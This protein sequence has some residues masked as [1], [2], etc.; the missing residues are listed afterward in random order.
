MI[1]DATVD[2]HLL[3]HFGQPTKTAKFSWGIHLVHVRH[4]AASRTDE[5]VD[6]YVTVG[7]RLARSGPHTTE[8]FIGLTP[9]QDDVAG[10]LAALW[11]YQTKQNVTFDHGHTIPGEKPLWRDTGLD[12]MLVLRQANSV[13][14][15][16]T[17]GQEH[18]EFMQVVPI[19]SDERRSV[20]REGVDAFLR[21]WEDRAVPFWDSRRR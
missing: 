2:A 4:W 9:G 15:M 20:H 18:V 8:F 5:G 10:P 13:I 1:S 3:G 21:D 11:R 17:A 19:T 14:P 12:S 6:L 7:A 16:V